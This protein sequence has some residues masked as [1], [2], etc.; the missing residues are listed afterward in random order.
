[1]WA[2]LYLNA[3][4]FKIDRKAKMMAKIIEDMV[5]NTNNFILNIVGES[6]VETPS[7]PLMENMVPHQIP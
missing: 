1:M 6:A 4:I 2:K 3:S 5:E 7:K